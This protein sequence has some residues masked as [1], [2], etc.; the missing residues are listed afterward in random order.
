MEL[1]HG[2]WC[3]ELCPSGLKGLES[4]CTQKLS[5]HKVW[6]CFYWNKVVPLTWA[7]QM[8]ASL[9]LFFC[10]C[11]FFLVAQVDVGTSILDPLI[12]DIIEL[13]VKSV[14]KRKLSTNSRQN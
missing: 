4:G 12:P 6:M 5:A 1:R 10:F 8:C 14:Q 2:V 3:G 7:G 11:F 9:F 13:S